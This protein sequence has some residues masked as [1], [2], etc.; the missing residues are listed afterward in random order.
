LNEEVANELKAY[1]PKIESDNK[2]IK[3]KHV[4]KN[5]CLYCT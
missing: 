3:F 2:I 1:Y 5:Q 4:P